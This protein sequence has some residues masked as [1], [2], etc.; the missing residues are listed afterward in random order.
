MGR[1]ATESLVLLA[2]ALVLMFRRMQG[3]PESER[4]VRAAMR[5]AIFDTDPDGDEFPHTADGPLTP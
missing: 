2:L 5:R 1:P 3:N 4:G